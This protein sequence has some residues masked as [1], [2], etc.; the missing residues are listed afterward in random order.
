MTPIRMAQYGTKHG[1]AI[2]KLLS[3]AMNPDVEVVGVFEP[4]P[5]PK[6]GAN[7]DHLRMAV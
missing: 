1:H 6:P 5:E 4:D 2:G 3:M 7:P